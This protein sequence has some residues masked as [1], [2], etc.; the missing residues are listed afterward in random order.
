MM[1]SPSAD[2]RLYHY[3]EK[4]SECRLQGRMNLMKSTEI[5]RATGDRPAADFFHRG[6]IPLITVQSPDSSSAY[7]P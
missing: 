5:C 7:I 1:V 6:I 2:R 3:A 4:R